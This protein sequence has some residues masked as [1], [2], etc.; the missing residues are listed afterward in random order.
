MRAHSVPAMNTRRIQ[1]EQSFVPLRCANTRVSAEH[2]SE[3]TMKRPL[4]T[5]GAGFIG[6]HVIDLLLA[7]GY[8]IRVL[9]NLN[10][11]VHGEN[12]QR[13]AYLAK[14]AELI[15]G[16]VRDR[17]AVDKAL[18]GVDGVIRLA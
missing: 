9:D 16:D 2:L 18:E 1:K 5:G 10:A 8:E 11:Q 6:S 15:V 17:T 4:V 7:S 3:R 12:A 13:P 14:D